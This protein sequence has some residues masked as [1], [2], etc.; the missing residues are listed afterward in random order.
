MSIGKHYVHTKNLVGTLFKWGH[1]LFQSLLKVPVE[2]VASSSI[3]EAVPVDQLPLGEK[4]IMGR[5]QTL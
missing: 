1:K 2:G 4:K 3:R 5:L